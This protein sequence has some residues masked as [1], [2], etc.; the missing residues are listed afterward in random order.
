MRYEKYPVPDEVLA[1]YFTRSFTDIKDLRRQVMIGLDRLMEIKG[2]VAAGQFSS[3]GK[4]IRAAGAMTDDIRR[5]TA[6]MCA[7]Q[8]EHIRSSIEH[9]GRAS[10]MEW[11]PLI[12]W[13]VWA[14]RYAMIV[15]G[16]TGVIADPKYTD[17]N[18]LVVD[19]M[20]S[21]ATGPR[22]ENY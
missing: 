18:Q 12:G 17:F 7:R 22:Q 4:V 13:A 9:F 19:L 6:Q 2:V 15:M 21:E 10:K 11:Q 1:R 3:D 8:S 20:G 16:N 5:F 14:G